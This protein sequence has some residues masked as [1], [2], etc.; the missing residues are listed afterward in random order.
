MDYHDI[1]LAI[2]MGILIL[3]SSITLNAM[4]SVLVVPDQKSIPFKIDNEI[5]Y[6]RPI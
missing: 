1:L 5:V 3:D 6:M 2:L 4:E